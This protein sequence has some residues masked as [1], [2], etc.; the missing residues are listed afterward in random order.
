MGFAYIVIEAIAIACI[1]YV[2]KLIVEKQV[3]RS[4]DSQK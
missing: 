3:E 2:L 4:K 1:I